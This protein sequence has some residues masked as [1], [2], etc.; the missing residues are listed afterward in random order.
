MVDSGIRTRQ[1]RLPSRGDTRHLY[2]T[3]H[4]RL[5]RLMNSACQWQFQEKEEN[6]AY[7]IEYFS[8]EENFSTEINKHLSKKDRIETT[9]C[10][11]ISVSNNSIINSD[12]LGDVLKLSNTE[13][14]NIK[15]S[16]SNFRR[17]SVFLKNKEKTGGFFLTVTNWKLNEECTFRC[18]SS[19][20][21]G[22]HLNIFCPPTLLKMVFRRIEALFLK[23]KHHKNFWPI[24]I[25]FWFFCKTFI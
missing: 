7:W 13:E 15:K 5:C 16:F 8:F 6:A 25:F 14:G 20:T 3:R 10:S 1:L 11:T 17:I 12:L 21:P 2:Y 19:K 24:E 4:Q 9:T 23:K 18:N 22:Y